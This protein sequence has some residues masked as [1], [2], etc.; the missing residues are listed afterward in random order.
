MKGKNDSIETLSWKDGIKV[1]KII[2]F[3]KIVFLVKITMSANYWKLCFLKE[4]IISG[5]TMWEYNVISFHV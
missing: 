1:V 5:K 4:N 3:M 2:P